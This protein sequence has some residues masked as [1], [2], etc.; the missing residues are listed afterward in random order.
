MSFRY[1]CGYCTVHSFVCCCLAVHWWLEQRAVVPDAVVPRK[2]RCQTR[3]R[4]VQWQPALRRS[5]LP[6]SLCEQPSANVC[7]HRSTYQ[8]REGG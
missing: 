1:Q 8:R 6:W 5:R 3:P 7:F 2:R 4:C